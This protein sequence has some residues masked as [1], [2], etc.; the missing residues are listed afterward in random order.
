MSSKNRTCSEGQ[1]TKEENGKQDKELC[2]KLGITH[3]GLYPIKTELWNLI[4][5]CCYDVS[6]GESSLQKD[7][8]NSK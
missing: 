7:K 2:M 3:K 8:E 6:T 5:Q 1:F 4:G